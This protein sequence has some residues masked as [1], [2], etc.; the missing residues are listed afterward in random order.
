V[1]RGQRVANEGNRQ[2]ALSVWPWRE[3]P[4]LQANAR[5]QTQRHGAIRALVGLVAAGALLALGQR[6]LAGVAA[7]VGLTTLLLALFSPDRA[8]PLLQRGL[9]RFGLV[10]GQLVT[11]LVL[12]PL[13]WL[14][15][16]PFGLLTRHG[17]RDPLHRAWSADARSYWTPRV[18]IADPDARRKRPF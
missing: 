16:T 17:K 13:Y 7:A 9:A 11:F 5:R 18:A 10:V 2:A 6:G 4:D 14:V 12:A 8:Y 15:L 1:A 3:T